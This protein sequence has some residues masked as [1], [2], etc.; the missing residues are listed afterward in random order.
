L[1]SKFDVVERDK[2]FE[3]DFFVSDFSRFVCPLCGSIQL[4]SI[5]E[6]DVIEAGENG[7]STDKADC[8]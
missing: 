4:C 3:N 2:G 8:S 7:K 1:V 6:E 5:K